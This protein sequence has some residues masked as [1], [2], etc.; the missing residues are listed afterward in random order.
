MTTAETPSFIKAYLRGHTTRHIAH[1]DHPSR[2]HTE[3]RRVRN[4][5]TSGSELVV[6]AQTRLRQVG[7]VT[8]SGQFT[9]ME[10]LASS[11]SYSPVY[12]LVAD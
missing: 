8:A 5:W 10:P 11:G 4:H 6:E 3:P 9:R 1:D 12:R 7:W 2:S